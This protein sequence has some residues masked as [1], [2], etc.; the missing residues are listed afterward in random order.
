M[1]CE[2]FDRELCISGKERTNIASL[3][4][5]FFPLSLSSHF[6]FDPTR[7]NYTFLFKNSTA[8]N[9]SLTIEKYCETNR[10]R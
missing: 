9:T 2:I 1:F 4:L 7:N 3:P 10:C 8:A 6:F 5:S